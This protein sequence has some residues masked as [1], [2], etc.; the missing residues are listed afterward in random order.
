[1]WSEQLPVSSGVP[2]HSMKIPRWH[3]VCATDKML[4]SIGMRRTNKKGWLKDA[5]RSEF[6]PEDV[7]EFYVLRKKR[8]DQRKTEPY[9]TV[10]KLK[11]NFKP[12]KATDGLAEQ[13]ANELYEKCG[14]DLS[15]RVENGVYRA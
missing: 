11:T 5:I 10:G 14:R 13:F 3:L 6:R 8:E 4:S 12:V 9:V 1:M 15:G 7:A 2:A